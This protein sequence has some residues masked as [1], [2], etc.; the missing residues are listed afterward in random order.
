MINDCFL[1]KVFTVEFSLVIY[2][3]I[4]LC[5]SCTEGE[6]VDLFVAQTVDKSSIT[7]AQSEG[8]KTLISRSANLQTKRGRETSS[9]AST[10]E[11]GNV[12][13]FISIYIWVQS[14]HRSYIII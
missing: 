14:S 12:N 2:I 13:Y 3:W 9:L 10:H 4:I 5:N 7:R 11:P 8:A 1:T 6:T